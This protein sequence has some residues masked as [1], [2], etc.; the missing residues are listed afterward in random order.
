MAPMLKQIPVGSRR[1]RSLHRPNMRC[2]VLPD[3]SV[4]AR[5]SERH[6]R[7]VECRLRLLVRRAH[8]GS[9]SACVRL[10]SRRRLAGLRRHEQRRYSAGQL[11]R[12]RRCVQ[13]RDRAGCLSIY[14]M[15]RLRP[16]SAQTCIP[17]SGSGVY[18]EHFASKRGYQMYDIGRSSKP[19]GI[20][21]EPAH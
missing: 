9:G 13:Q 6:P 1:S 16:P 20:E 5:A 3:G 21:K 12:I 7:R 18:M 14:V 4:H 10:G 15:A 17:A 2:R 19:A 11:P 8:L